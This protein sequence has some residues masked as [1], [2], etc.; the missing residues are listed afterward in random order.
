[1]TEKVEEELAEEAKE[2]AADIAVNGDRRVPRFDKDPKPEK[3]WP[4]TGR[5][6]KGSGI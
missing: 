6:P 4:G 2:R 1:M 3:E 5:S